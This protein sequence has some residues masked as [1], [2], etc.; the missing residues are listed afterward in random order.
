MNSVKR[1]R[2]WLAAALCA[3]GAT[4]VAVVVVVARG[5]VAA[6]ALDPQAAAAPASTDLL[7]QL[8]HDPS[9]HR[10]WAIK[11]RLDVQ[12]ERYDAAAAAYK[13][14]LSGSRSKV[15]RDPDVW[16]EYAEALALSR[17]GK[18]AGEPLQQ[19]NK[20]LSLQPDHP[21][22]LDLAASAAWDAGNFNAAAGYWKRLLAQLPANDPR[23]AGVLAALGRA[24]R[25]ARFA[26]P[27]QGTVRAT[28]SKH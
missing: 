10:A 21:G 17:G 9:D 1:R 26:L 3:V 24:D 22:A 18:L 14:A 2:L 23:R 20:A 6:T 19:V 16:V 27:G 25:Q 12:A 15:A 7:R 5:G 8:Q 4:A 28:E 11:A 13:A